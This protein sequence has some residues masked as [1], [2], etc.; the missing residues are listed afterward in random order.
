MDVETSSSSSSDSIL[1]KQK[2]ISDILKSV[3]MVGDFP[4]KTGT[5]R[6]REGER[7][8]E[9]ERETERETGGREGDG[10][11]EGQ[12]EEEGDGKGQGEGQGK[13]Q[14]FLVSSVCSEQHAMNAA[15]RDTDPE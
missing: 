3:T 13:K 2:S 11:G 7:G 1:S 9:E 4:G 10:G 12:G 5:G 8:R 15:K 14:R 6:G